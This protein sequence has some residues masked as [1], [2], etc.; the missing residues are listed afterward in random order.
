M[1]RRDT[2]AYSH[3][4]Y[5]EEHHDL[6][7][8][9]N[10]LSNLVAVTGTR[11]ECGTAAGESRPLGTR[12]FGALL[13]YR[14]RRDLPER[15]RAEDATRNRQVGG[16]EADQ[17]ILDTYAGLYGTKVLVD[18]RTMP[19]GWTPFFPWLVLMLGVFLVAWLLKR[20]REVP[21]AATAVSAGET[22][23]LPDFDDE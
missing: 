21:R 18:P 23:T 12:G 5:T 1:R 22:A 3:D 6:K 19:R 8:R 20:W 10:T 14:I 11:G 4:L 15:N 2:L 13:L 16:G 7:I 9:P 17:D